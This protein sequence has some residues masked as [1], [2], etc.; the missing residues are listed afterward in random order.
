MDVVGSVNVTGGVYV[1]GS[2]FSGGSSQW[3]TIGSNIS[4][5]TG[6]V[7]IGST[8]PQYKLDVAGSV[9]VTG[10]FYVNGSALTSGG[11]IIVPNT[12]GLASSTWTANNVNWTVSASTNLSGYNPYR[13]FNNTPADSWANTSTTYTTTGNSTGI[14]TT[15]QGGIGSIQGDW[16]QLQSSIPL[17]MYSYQLATGGGPFQIPN[18]FYI[19]GSMDG[20][21]WYPI[22]KSVGVAQTNT[23]Y[24]TYVPGTIIVATSG[25]QTFGNSSLTTTTYSTTSNAYTYF[26][27]IGTNTYGT[28]SYLEI[29]E[30]YVTFTTPS[31]SGTSSQWSTI[32]SNISYTGNVGIGTTAPQYAMDVAG[33]VNV[34][35]GLYVNGAPY[36]L[37]GGIIVPNT[38]GLS[39]NT[40]ST[41]NGI[42]WISSCSPSAASAAYAA[43][44]NTHAY[45]QNWLGQLSPAGQYNSSGN[46]IGSASTTVLGGIGAVSG[47]WVQIQSSFPLTLYSYIFAVG[48]WQAQQKTMYVVGSNDGSSWYPLQLISL[49]AN[50]FTTDFSKAKTSILMN[51]AGTQAITADTTQNATTTTYSY[52]T[53]TFTYFRFITTANYLTWQDCGQV[54]EL[55]LAFTTPSSASTATQWTTSG[56]SISYAGNVGIGTTSPQYAMDVVGGA[57]MSQRV[58]QQYYGSTVFNCNSSDG[59]G[60]V[61]YGGNGGS[62]WSTSGDVIT[63]GVVGYIS[64]SYSGSYGNTV[65][66]MTKGQY[67]PAFNGIY[68][69]SWTTRMAGSSEVIISKNRGNQNDYNNYGANPNYTPNTSQ[70]GGGM[71]AHVAVINN[72][73]NACISWTG[74]LSTSDYVCLGQY[75]GS[76]GYSVSGNVIRSSVT[77]TLIQST[78]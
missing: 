38:T 17:V 59:S 40:W 67:F 65:M 29:G 68:T 28:N 3:S 21:T 66:T 71:L 16:V 64:Y 57:R 7:G 14:T 4:Y 56:N 60:I 53:Q 6:N 11:G 22:Q 18:T 50:P 15:I 33:T 24:N 37:G 58:I 36:S 8:T 54:G 26:R 75:N 77:F 61:V 78:A 2:A 1:N 30:W 19:I 51:Y 42:T 34:T 72:N 46:Y 41:T 73:N 47:E 23:A 76:G 45:G 48:S 5:S 52:T 43:F 55:Y 10:G 69:I 9:N 62:A 32:G 35:G 13:M 49:A 63:T 25:S 39:S 70:N 27:I 74:Y 20:T 44:N 31:S 12:S